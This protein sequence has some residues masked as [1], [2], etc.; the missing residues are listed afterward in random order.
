[1]VT[2]FMASEGEIKK[3]PIIFI[4]HLHNGQEITHSPEDNGH[5][6]WVLGTMESATS[7][8]PQR[9]GRHTP[10]G[11]LTVGTKTLA[12]FVKNNFVVPHQPL[13]HGASK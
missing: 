5:P 6:F 11:S 4:L 3:Q 13:N 9:R 8:K 7:S 1:M 12:C 2:V 10:V